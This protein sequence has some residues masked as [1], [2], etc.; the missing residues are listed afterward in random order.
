[1]IDV[2]VPEKSSECHLYVSPT[3]SNPPG[4]A[5]SALGI[6]CRHLTVAQTLRGIWSLP[7]PIS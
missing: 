3:A 4:A 1:M 5:P 7:P 2:K 6:K